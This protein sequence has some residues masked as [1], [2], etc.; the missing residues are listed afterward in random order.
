MTGSLASKL[1]LTPQIVKSKEDRESSEAQVQIEDRTEDKKMQ[2]TEYDT[3]DD[4][5]LLAQLAKN[6]E[7]E[8]PLDGEDR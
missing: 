6:N 7:I 3:S 2:S 1:C 4:R 8:D 5:A